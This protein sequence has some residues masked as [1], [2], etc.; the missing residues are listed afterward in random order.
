MRSL[1]GGGEPVAH[2]ARALEAEALEQEA[3]RAFLSCQGVGSE[4]QTL[5][6]RLEELQ[7]NLM[8]RIQDKLA[9]Q[10]RKLMQQ[11]QLLQEQLH[12]ATIVAKRKAVLPPAP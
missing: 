2:E 6:E 11:Q 12:E 3:L 9:T 8:G 4:T 10:L 1:G 5:G 7:D